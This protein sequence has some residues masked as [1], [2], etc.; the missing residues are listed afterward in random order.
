MRKMCAAAVA[1]VLACGT[2]ASA[3]VPEACVPAMNAWLDAKNVVLE[4]VKQ[5]ARLRDEL[6]ALM[7][8]YGTEGGATDAELDVVDANLWVSERA[9]ARARKAEIT[10]FHDVWNCVSG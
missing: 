4:S 3:H 10:A 6:N 9:T 8:T 5:D 2:V 7:E 1:A